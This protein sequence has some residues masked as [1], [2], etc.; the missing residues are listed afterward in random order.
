MK[1]VYFRTAIDRIGPADHAGAEVEGRGRAVARRPTSV[2]AA[3][4]LTD[5]MPFAAARATVPYLAG[6]IGHQV[7]PGQGDRAGRAR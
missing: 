6:G 7:A 5:E 4:L 2:A 1:P 3:T